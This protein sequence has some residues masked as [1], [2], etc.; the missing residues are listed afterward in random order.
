MK[1]DEAQE[2]IIEEYIKASTAFPPM[3]SRHEGYAILKE[4]VDELW[5][6][7]KEASTLDVSE[8]R[9][10]ALTIEAKQVGAMALRFLIDR[11]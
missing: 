2:L 8:R 11:C 4:E 6:N 3:R 5:D 10:E 9:R 1:F 7:I